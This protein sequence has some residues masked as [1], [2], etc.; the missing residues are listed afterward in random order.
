[1]KQSSQKTLGLGKH[2]VEIIGVKLLYGRHQGRPIGYFQVTFANKDGRFIEDFINNQDGR[3]R[4]M[5]PL[6]RRFGKVPE[7][8]ETSEISNSFRSIEG[9]YV[10]L[11]IVNNESGEKET[12]RY[13]VPDQVFPN[14]LDHLFEHLFKPKN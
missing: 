10:T 4:K 13:E 14:S 6:F 7:F 1:M 11:E 9:R 5:E 12:M 3:E 8:W 2:I